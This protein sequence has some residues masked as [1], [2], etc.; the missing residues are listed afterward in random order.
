MART[1]VLE[2]HKEGDQVFQVRFHQELPAGVTLSNATV[3]VQKRTVG[4]DPQDWNAAA[5]VTVSG[6]LVVDAI[7]DDEVTN[8]GADQAVQFQVNADPQVQPDETDDPVPGDNYRVVVE[9]DRSDAGDVIGKV[10]LR[11]MP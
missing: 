3:E 4:S 9:A 1:R 8:L 5:G 2:Y 10:P 11:V 7:A 6:V